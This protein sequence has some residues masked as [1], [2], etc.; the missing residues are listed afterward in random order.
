MKLEKKELDVLQ[1]Q[2]LDDLLRL[3]YRYEESAG[4]QEILAEFDA[5]PQD[6]ADVDEK[7]RQ[8]TFD[9]AMQQLDAQQAAARR[10]RTRRLLTRFAG[11]AAVILLLLAVA[12]PLAVAGIDV[13]RNEFG[14]FFFSDSV[15]DDDLAVDYHPLPPADFT[16][17]RP[18]MTWTGLYLPAYMPEGYI[19]DGCI[20]S[21]DGCYL[22]L[23]NEG[24]GD[25]LRL[26]EQL[27]A[28][29]PLSGATVLRWVSL[30]DGAACVEQ[31]E[32]GDLVVTWRQHARWYRLRSDRLPEAEL[33][34]IAG[35]LVPYAGEEVL[36]ALQE[37]SVS[38]AAIPAGY[39][40]QFFPT[41]T[42]EGF[43]CTEVSDMLGMY[44]AE[45][46]A[47]DG[48]EWQWSEAAGDSSVLDGNG[49]EPVYV[50]IGSAAGAMYTDGEYITLIWMNEMR[51][52]HLKGRGMS[53]EEMLGIAR[54]VRLIDRSTAQESLPVA[55]TAPTATPALVME[56]ADWTMPYVPTW[57][58]EGCFAPYAYSMSAFGANLCY[59][60]EDGTEIVLTVNRSEITFSDNTE[61]LMSFPVDVNGSEARMTFSPLGS[62]GVDLSWQADGFWFYIH[63][64]V[65][66]EAEVVQLARSLRIGTP[67]EIAA[68]LQQ[69]TCQPEMPQGEPMR[70]FPMALLAD[71]AV[72]SGQ[73]AL[74]GMNR[75]TLCH[76]GTGEVVHLAQLAPEVE[77]LVEGGPDFNV[78]RASLEVAG[79]QVT[80]YTPTEGSSDWAPTALLWREGEHLYMLLSTLPH[81]ALYEIIG[82]MTPVE[83]AAALATPTPARTEPPRVQPAPDGWAGEHFITR[84]P[85]GYE[86]VS[87]TADRAL[88]RNAAGDAFTFLRMPDDWS[89]REE[90][91]GAQTVFDSLFRGGWCVT[92]VRF[93]EETF[94]TV[95]RFI[96]SV[97]GCWYAIEGEEA[98]SFYANYV[99]KIE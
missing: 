23:L 33:L 9:R 80:V 49:G 66:H 75:L 72:L 74:E 18:S 40:G 52:F 6:A 50:E 3:A 7:Q 71:W 8:A 92:V 4:V 78:A 29:Q 53:Q 81:E 51:M 20:P 46:C 1:E 16:Y 32:D 14:W 25:Y 55:L 61:Y 10:G 87:A 41:W 17:M 85:A 31:A 15:A 5:L 22:T 76:A 37:E 48:R 45:F 35:S 36:S 68:A 39:G 73:S 27:D 69:S 93:D 65:G 58:P 64:A 12:A 62:G 79:R 21:G 84:V 34:G 59:V 54:S 60:F 47:G 63:G 26:A 11:V 89:I 97:D 88:W 42:P 13:L 44:F 70:L 2:H 99:Q 90:A 19:G 86:F 82:M 28:P 83:D 94:G 96:F 38:G 95:N 30:G 43:V 67:Q 56:L 91:E 57:C 77:L 98:W 24:S